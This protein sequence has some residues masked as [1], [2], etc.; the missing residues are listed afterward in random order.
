MEL[1][2]M[3]VLGTRAFGVSVR[4]RPGAIIKLR[5]LLAS[6]SRSGR[7]EFG[8]LHKR[9]RFT[10]PKAKVMLRSRSE[11]TEM[12]LASREIFGFAS[13]AREVRDCEKRKKIEG[14]VR[15]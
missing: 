3:R 4:V 13:R 15:K 2:D 5:L 9:S 14:E 11:S 6:H 1:V 7:S 8:S 10:S 12:K